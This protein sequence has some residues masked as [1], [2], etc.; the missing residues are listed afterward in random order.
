MK[1]AIASVDEARIQAV[2][3]SGAGFPFLLMMS[4]AWLSAGGVSYLLPISIAGWV[5]PLAGLPA[6]VGSQSCSMSK[7]FTTPA[8]SLVRS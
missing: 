3:S 7:R 6:M 2:L 4:F 5:Y 8:S 1:P